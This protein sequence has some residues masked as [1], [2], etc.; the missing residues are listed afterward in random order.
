MINKKYISKVAVIAAMVVM[1]MIGSAY[2]ESRHKHAYEQ[3]H[4]DA[5]RDAHD[6]Y[7]FEEV[8]FDEYSEH[9]KEVYETYP[10]TSSIRKDR[11]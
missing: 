5:L 11:D 3:G 1:F 4:Y 8:T 7:G 10:K 2:G 6:T 9:V